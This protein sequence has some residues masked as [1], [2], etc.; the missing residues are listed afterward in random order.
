M[1]RCCKSQR[2]G[3]GLFEFT[4]A[5][6]VILYERVAEFVLERHSETQAIS[7]TIEGRPRGVQAVETIHFVP[8]GQ[9]HKGIVGMDMR[10]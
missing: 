6:T 10:M 5:F 7:A 2:C 1:L 4:H 9:Q 8:C 3:E